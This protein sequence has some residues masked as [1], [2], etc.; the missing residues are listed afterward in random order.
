M[1]CMQNKSIQLRKSCSIQNIFEHFSLDCCYNTKTDAIR[2][3]YI[4]FPACCVFIYNVFLNKI[5]F[6]HFIHYKICHI[7]YCNSTESHHS[8][9]T[10]PPCRNQ[11]HFQI[12]SGQSFH[13]FHLCLVMYCRLGLHALYALWFQFLVFQVYALFLRSG[14]WICLLCLF[15]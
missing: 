2:T 11:L 15:L 4:L 6:V 12:H 14:F 1:S 13:C 3:T 5:T 7:M 9:Q 8:Q 10:C